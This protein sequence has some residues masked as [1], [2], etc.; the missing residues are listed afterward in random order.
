[1]LVGC[2]HPPTSQSSPLHRPVSRQAHAARSGER[3]LFSANMLVGCGIFLGGLAV[4]GHYKL[5]AVSAKAAAQLKA[6]GADEERLVE[7][8]PLTNGEERSAS[9]R[10]EAS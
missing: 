8:V 10:R 6:G 1:M 7:A 9:L 4:Y 5:R 3:N 2:D